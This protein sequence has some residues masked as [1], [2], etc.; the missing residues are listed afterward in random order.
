[1]LMAAVHSHSELQEIGAIPTS[2]LSREVAQFQLSCLR[3]HVPQAMEL[4]A[5]T[6]LNPVIDADTLNEAKAR[7]CASMV[8]RLATDAPGS[9]VLATYDAEDMTKTPD[10]VL[11]EVRAAATTARRAWVVRHM[12][13]ACGGGRCC[14]RLRLA[15]I[16]GLG[17]PCC[18]PR[19][20]GRR[21]VLT[22]FGSSDNSPWLRARP[23]ARDRAAHARG[24]RRAYVAENTVIA[25]TGA[26][27][28]SCRR[29]RAC[30]R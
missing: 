11:Q 26:R 28:A 16:R 25:G 7:A 6:L 23:V 30:V 4:L 9:Q 1:M 10:L 13:L 12:P 14:T 2:L 5:D 22:A 27:A 17:T 20:R 18:V 29:L 15:A 3:E 24:G 21:S 19:S 8:G